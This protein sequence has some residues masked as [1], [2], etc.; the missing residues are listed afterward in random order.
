MENSNDG[1]RKIFR[2]KKT[3]PLSCRKQVNLLMRIKESK[4]KGLQKSEGGNAMAKPS[5]GN[6]MA[7]PS[8]GNDMKK[9]PRM[10]GSDCSCHKIFQGLENL[11]ARYDLGLGSKSIK[12]E[13]AH[14]VSIGT[15]ADTTA[16]QAPGS[17]QIAVSA[18]KSYH[19]LGPECMRWN[20]G[21]ENSD[22]MAK[23]KRS[24][25][26][27]EPCKRLKISANDTSG[28]ESEESEENSKMSL[29]EVR[30]MVKQ[31][32]FALFKQF[33]IKFEE[34]TERVKKVECSPK[35]E[36]MVTKLQAQMFKIKRRLQ[37]A[38]ISV[39]KVARPMKPKISTNV[40]EASS[41]QP[42]LQQ[43][44]QSSTAATRPHS[45]GSSSSPS[46][47]TVRSVQVSPW[48]KT[49][50]PDC[51][52]VSSAP[53]AA[54][55]ASSCRNET[56]I[57]GTASARSSVPE[58]EVESAQSSGSESEENAGQNRQ[59]CISDV[60]KM[61]DL[62][63]DDHDDQLAAVNESSVSV[64]RVGLTLRLPAKDSVSPT[65]TLPPLPE[66]AVPPDLPAVAASFNMPQKP[67]LKVAK[68]ENP[69]AVGILWDLSQID[70]SVASIQSYCL[71]VL[72]ENANVRKLR[73]RSMGFIKAIQLP[74]CCR[75]TKLNPGRYHFAVVGKD[76][77]GRYGPYS[78]IQSTTVSAVDC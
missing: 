27:S 78:D 39:N 19:A 76:I 44:Q 57:L 52:L 4:S 42:S 56:S 18:N 40:P 16:R 14:D 49:D 72:H 59:V 47:A 22:A 33:D 1:Q 70:T 3:M 11:E 37:E 31:E 7:K 34:L 58:K 61:I 12:M 32:A 17:S 66:T 69:K 6:A 10:P 48:E 30:D 29:G 74:M 26:E 65:R 43:A 50:G 21:D 28:L 51:V 54:R 53:K 45:L 24:L 60:E 46:S 8:P 55:V 25:Y 41:A 9:P 38:L 63:T 62:T 75:L 15:A 73:W 68:I 5:P 71:Y 77:Y 36:V 35:H 20:V 64:A 13:K 23:R 2:A 67:E